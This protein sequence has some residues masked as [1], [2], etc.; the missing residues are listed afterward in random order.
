MATET[1]AGPAAAPD[2]ASAPTLEYRF[3][4]SWNVQLSYHRYENVGQFDPEPTQKQEYEAGLN[5]AVTKRQTIGIS[6]FRH[7]QFDAPND[8]FSFVKMKYSISF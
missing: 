5:F 4:S 2:G 8:Q 3:A 1:R 7:I 6:F